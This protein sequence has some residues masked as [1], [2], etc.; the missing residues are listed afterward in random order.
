MII[1]SDK[2]VSRIHAKLVI[3]KLPS[4]TRTIRIVDVSKYGTFVNKQQGS[5]DSKPVSELPNQEKRLETADLVAF[6][7]AIFRL[8]YLNHLFIRL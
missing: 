4:N 3:D 1:Q 5:K 6:G 2:G 7:T 8:G